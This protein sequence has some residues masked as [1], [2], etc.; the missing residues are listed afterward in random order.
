MC[1]NRIELFKLNEDGSI[2]EA[3]IESLLQSSHTQSS[4]TPKRPSNAFIMYRQA[5]SKQNEHVDGKSLSKEAASLWKNECFEIRNYFSKL[6][7]AYREE[8]KRKYP[9]FKYGSKKVKKVE[10]FKPFDFG[11]VAKKVSPVSVANQYHVNHSI[12]PSSSYYR[13]P[14]GDFA[15]SASKYVNPSNQNYQPLPN[16]NANLMDTFYAPMNYALTPAVAAKSILPEGMKHSDIFGSNVAFDGLDT[17]QT[18]P[19]EYKLFDGQLSALNQQYGCDA[20]L[21][22]PFYENNV[23]TQSYAPFAYEAGLTGEVDSFAGVLNSLNA[24]LQTV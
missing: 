17:L 4:D 21:F 2:D 22:E 7:T 19:N 12:I 11:K 9:D 3:H 1:E 16:M 18:T 10:R 24:F 20:S 15:N 5:L 23:Q 6:A 14:N 8:H 13:E